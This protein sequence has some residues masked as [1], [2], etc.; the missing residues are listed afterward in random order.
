M[1]TVAYTF[2]SRCGGGGHTELTV[3]LGGA[4]V[5]TFT[6]NTDEIRLALS[7]LTDEERSEAALIVLKL[8]FAGMTRQQI[9]NAFQAG[10]GVVS[11]TI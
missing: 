2:V 4:N 3:T 10:G 1:A 5:G 6:Y 7:N 9:I 8:H 11:I